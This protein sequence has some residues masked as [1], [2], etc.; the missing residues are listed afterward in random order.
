M[1]T[2]DWRQLKSRVCKFELKIL[3]M[4]SRP[5][6]LFRNILHVELDVHYRILYYNN[7]IIIIGNY[8]YAFTQV[9]V[10][11]TTRKDHNRVCV[12]RQKSFEPVL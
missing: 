12:T 11:L 7:N 8:L 2:D 4:I 5:F 6:A 10:N 9:L 3:I 1:V